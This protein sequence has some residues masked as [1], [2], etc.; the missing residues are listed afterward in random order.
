MD[1]NKLTQ[2]EMQYLEYW[3]TRQE[4]R[5]IKILLTVAWCLI[6][7]LFLVV[8]VIIPDIKI[9][10]RFA[11]LSILSIMILLLA[12]S[13][14]LLLNRLKEYRSGDYE[15]YRTKILRK[16]VGYWKN[17]RVSF[18]TYYYQCRGIKAQVMPVSKKLYDR[19]KTG[20]NITIVK[21][22][23][24]NRYVFLGITFYDDIL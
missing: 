22:K 2:R 7:M 21:L 16:E 23:Q 20:D 14:K 6:G 1:Q 24:Q 11:G 8:T 3:I 17:A 19:T 5:P 15:I 13:T 9:H 12:F 10:E 18:N 4:E